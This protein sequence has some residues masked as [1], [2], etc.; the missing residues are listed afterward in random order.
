M[1]AGG[2]PRRMSLS[3]VALSAGA[4][5]PEVLRGAAL[6]VRN[7]YDQPIA[8]FVMV[9]PTIYHM[10]SV[11]ADPAEFAEA[12]RQHGVTSAPAVVTLSP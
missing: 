6:L 1:T 8:L 4:T 11:L 9:S 7:T 12:L 2:D 10:Y 5:G 3:A